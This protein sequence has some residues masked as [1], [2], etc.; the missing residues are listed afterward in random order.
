LKR[1]IEDVL[2][3]RDIEDKGLK[4]K[5]LEID[6]RIEDSR[7]IERVLRA[8]DGRYIEPGPSGLITRGEGG[9]TTYR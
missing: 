3:G 8:F 6:R 9:Y 7:E 4:E 2:S 5:I 1:Y